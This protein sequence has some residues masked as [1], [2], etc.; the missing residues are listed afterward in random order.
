MQ[1]TAWGYLRIIKKP[2]RESIFRSDKEWRETYSLLLISNGCKVPPET[3]FAVKELRGALIPNYTVENE[4]IRDLISQ[5]LGEGWEEDKDRIDILYQSILAVRKEEDERINR[6]TTLYT[7]MNKL[8]YTHGDKVVHHHIVP[9]TLFCVF[10]E[11]RLTLRDIACLVY[12]ELVLTDENN[13]VG[14]KWE[15]NDLC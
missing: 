11:L 14:Q 2:L 3:K 13:V 4:D 5:Y 8:T 1:L 9:K 7:K 15:S 6:Y 12:Y 10:R